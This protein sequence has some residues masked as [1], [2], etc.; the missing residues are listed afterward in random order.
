MKM[1]MKGVLGAVVLMFALVANVSGQSVE[2]LSPETWDTIGRINVPLLQQAGSGVLLAGDGTQFL[3]LTARHVVEDAAWATVTFRNGKTYKSKRILRD[4]MGSDSAVLVIED[5]GLKPVDVADTSPQRG[6]VILA[7][8]YGGQG[9][10]IGQLNVVQSETRGQLMMT[11]K[12]RK[13]DSGGPIFDLRS[14]VVGINSLSTGPMSGGQRNTAVSWRPVLAFVHRVRGGLG[15]PA[16]T[17]PKEVKPE[18][19]A[20]PVTGLPWRNYS[21]A[22]AINGQGIFQEIHSRCTP[23]DRSRAAGGDRVTFTHE[24]THQLHARIRNGVG[25]TGRVNAVYVGGGKALV[26]REPKLTLSTVRRYVTK[27]KNSTYNLYLVTQGRWW[28]NEPL[29]VLDEAVSYANG[30][31]AAIEGGY[32]PHGSDMF[33][34][35]FCHYADALV[36]AVEV[37]D[38]SYPDLETLRA[39]VAWHKARCQKLAAA[40]RMT[41]S[42]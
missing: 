24:L 15:V 34:M 19:E 27:Y 31:Q 21:P 4:K 12:L 7:C 30:T 26:M 38:P 32:D 11:G 40:G 33:M 14:R 5:P 28:E 39:F 17:P 3:V 23:A 16:P 29:Y 35:Y 36:Q 2:E 22:G 6:E 10:L 20:P 42:P 18:P 1:K 37:H 41:L 8:G 25:G 13:G 9:R